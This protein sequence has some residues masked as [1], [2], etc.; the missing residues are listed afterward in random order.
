MTSNRNPDGSFTRHP[1]D[2]LIDLIAT[3]LTPLFIG[4]AGG[5]LRYARMAAIEMIWSHRVTNQADLLQ[6]VQI[7]AFSLASIQALCTAMTGDVPPQ[8]LLRL[9]NGAERLSREEGRVRK[10]RQ[11]E[12]ACAAARP[13]APQPPPATRPDPVPPPAPRAE[14]AAETPADRMHD[15]R[16]TLAAA[17]ASKAAKP[18]TPKPA[19]ALAP[20]AGTMAAPHL[21]GGLGMAPLVFDDEAM[22]QILKLA[23]HLQTNGAFG[24]GSGGGVSWDAMIGAEGE[25][26]GGSPAL[27]DRLTD[28]S[29]HLVPPVTDG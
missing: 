17:Y 19:P 13:P 7:I 5:D 14:P 28:P 25:A 15:A 9:M 26:G 1:S 4:A 20:T 22:A 18:Q 3:L 11:Q 10:S 2:V 23:K 24:S 16:E 27:R 6:V 8:L 29:R 21:L 12:Q